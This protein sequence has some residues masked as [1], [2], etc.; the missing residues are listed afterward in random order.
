MPRKGFIIIA[1]LLIVASTAQ[2]AGA[3]ERRR[4]HKTDHAS[5]NEQFRNA[6]N[7]M[8]LPSQPNWYS[9][10]YSAPAGR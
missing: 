7:S 2:L 9:G 8:A 10:G 1:A 6:R 5:A 4:A 3:S